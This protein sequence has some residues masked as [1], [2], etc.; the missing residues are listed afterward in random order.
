MIAI[1]IITGISV[2]SLIFNQNYTA[3]AQQQEQALASKGIS[4]DNATFSHH[5]ASVNGIQLHM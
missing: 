3:I 1:V 5:M 4:Y 2:S